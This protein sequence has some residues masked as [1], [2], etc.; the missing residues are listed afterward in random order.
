VLAC[1]YGLNPLYREA[2]GSGSLRVVGV[3]ANCEARIVELP[4]HRF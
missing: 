3:D 1:S 4:E 2:I